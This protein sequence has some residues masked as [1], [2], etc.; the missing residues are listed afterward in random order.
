MPTGNIR[1]D[2]KPN[3]ARDADPIAFLHDC[4]PGAQRDHDAD[5]LVPGNER[6]RGL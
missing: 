5:C 1:N 3:R 4:Y 6:W 2:R